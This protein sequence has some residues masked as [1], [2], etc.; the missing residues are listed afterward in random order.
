MDGWIS[1]SIFGPTAS[2]LCAIITIYYWGLDDKAW[3]G[4]DATTRK[5]WKSALLELHFGTV[6]S[7]AW[8][9]IGVHPITNNLT[10]IES[11]LAIAID[12]KRA[13]GN[14][15]DKMHTFLYFKNMAYTCTT[16]SNGPRM[17]GVKQLTWLDD[18][19][20]PPSVSKLDTNSFLQLLYIEMHKQIHR[21]FLAQ[22][23]KNVASILSLVPFRQVLFLRLP[24]RWSYCNHILVDWPAP[25]RCH[26]PGQAGTLRKFRIADTCKMPTVL[27]YF[28]RR[29]LVASKS[30]V[31]E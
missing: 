27:P 11:N 8:F 7:V 5:N 6:Q 16:Y 25:R 3:I 10:A 12:R 4:K 13:G 22:V 19:T 31:N 9:M 17:L 18:S 1:F 30:K 23:P 26:L 15:Q 2:T 20:Q 28:Y 24:S 29:H 14:L 21:A